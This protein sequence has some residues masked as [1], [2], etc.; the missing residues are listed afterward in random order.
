[1][2]FNDIIAFLTSL[3]VQAD[4]VSVKIAFLVI[5]GFLV[6]MIIFILLN[7]HYLQWL[8]VQDYFEFFTFRQFGIRRINRIWRKINKRLDTGLESEYKLAIIEAD[9]ML[10][11]SLKRMGYAGQTLEE[12]LQKMTSA[13]LP[14]IDQVYE[15]HRSRNNL[16]H[17]PDYRLTLDEARKTM[18]IYAKAFG[19]LQ[20]LT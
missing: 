20:I 12:R 6:V 3:E 8:F 4:L 9:D 11:T 13:I 19:D 7:S 16:V 17:D 14:N 10:N 15:A 18:D 2:N 5:A 1:M